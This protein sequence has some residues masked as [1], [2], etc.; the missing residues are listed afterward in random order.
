M[1][2]CTLLFHRSVAEADDGGSGSEES[3]FSEMLVPFGE[4]SSNDMKS[5]VAFEFEIALEARPLDE[6][7]G[8]AVAGKA[9]TSFWW[10]CEVRL[11]TVSTSDFEDG[12]ST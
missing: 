1:L 6:T 11:L 3:C 12:R 10:N 9:R 2:L 5:T 4:A 7:A 8:V